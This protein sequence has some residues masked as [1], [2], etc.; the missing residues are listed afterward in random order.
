MESIKRK[1]EP[2]ENRV[3]TA[4]NLDAIVLKPWKIRRLMY[5]LRPTVASAPSDPA[6]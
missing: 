5:V 1:S 2:Y 4:S 6:Y 3:P